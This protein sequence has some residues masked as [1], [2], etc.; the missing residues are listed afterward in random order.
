[1][2]ESVAKERSYYLLLW[3]EKNGTINEEWIPCDNF[4]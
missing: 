1:M 3:L 4:L 2:V